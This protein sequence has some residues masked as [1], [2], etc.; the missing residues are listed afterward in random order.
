MLMQ[1]VKMRQN[2][3]THCIYC[4][5][6]DTPRDM[7]ERAISLGFTSL[8]FSSHANTVINDTCELGANREIYVN[9]IIRLRSEYEG[10]IEILLGTELD[11][12]SAAVQDNTQYEYKI[13]SVH[14]GKV[15]DEYVSY[16]LGIKHSEDAIRRHFG[17]DVLA[18]ARLYYE[19]MADMPNKIS[20]DFVG[21]FDLVTKFEEKAPHL[22]ATGSP[23]YKKMALDALF[24]VREKFEF[25]EVNTG[26]IGRG[27]KS[28]PYPAPFILDAMR[29]ARCKL[30]IT[31]DCHNKDYLDC[32]FDTSVELIKAH[33]FTE[34]YEL[35]GG[36]FIGRKI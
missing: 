19:T 11:Y 24:A 6:R 2:L 18:Y 29:D 13:A 34:I 12:Y 7:I 28:T 25:F 1:N 14:Y 21:H 33:G 17:G 31:S 4:D 27:Y 15:G 8:G 23:E 10:K 22:Y 36:R 9:E 32:G 16:D 3:H 30:I 5:G 35:C 20:G 26:T